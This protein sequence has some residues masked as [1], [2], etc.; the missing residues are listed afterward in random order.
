MS[1]L[2]TDSMLKQ[3]RRVLGLCQEHRSGSHPE[4]G[5]VGAELEGVVEA[6]GAARKKEHAAAR[7]V[8]GITGRDDRREVA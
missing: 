2:C 7:G 3:A 6:V 5:R 4:D 8:Q 1:A